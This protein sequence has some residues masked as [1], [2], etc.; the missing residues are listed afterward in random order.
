M[1][2]SSSNIVLLLGLIITWAP[3]FDPK[4]DLAVL[5]CIDADQNI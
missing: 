5:S 1:I 2:K 3:V 4:I